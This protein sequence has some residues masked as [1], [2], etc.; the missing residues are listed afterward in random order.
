MSYFYLEGFPVPGCVAA[1]F[2]QCL[3]SLYFSFLH[4]NT[5]EIISQYLSTLKSNWELRE[6]TIPACGDYYL[7]TKLQCM[8]LRPIAGRKIKHFS[9]GDK[10]QYQISNSKDSKRVRVIAYR[11]PFLLNEKYED[12]DYTVSHLC[13]D[14]EC[15][16]PDHHVFEP[17]A[18][19][20]GRNGCP[21]GSHCHHKKKCLMPGPYH[22]M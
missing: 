6:K 4:S 17:L 7:E 9:K 1:G 13:H 19:N 8:F 11:V 2:P 21:G 5:M 12:P 3:N 15:M 16:N 10:W 18:V 20:K 14:N 22:N